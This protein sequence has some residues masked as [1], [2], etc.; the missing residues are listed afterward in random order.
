MMQYSG[1]TALD[2]QPYGD[3]AVII[4]FG[5]HISEE[6]NSRVQAAAACMEE[7]PF[8]GFVECIPAFTSLTVFYDVSAV[9]NIK[10]GVSP[11]AL[12]KKEVTER[13]SH[14]MTGRKK[15]RR[16]MEIPVCYGGD[17]GPDLEEVAEMN[18]L[19]P[20]DVTRIHTEGEYLV[21]MLGFAPGFPFLGGMSERIRAPRKASPRPSIPAGSVGIAGMQTGVYPIS[22]PGGWQLIGSTPLRLFRPE[23]HPPSLLRAGDTVKFV[24]ITAE[25][26]SRI[27]EGAE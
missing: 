27:K 12:V 14:I 20:E 25:E 13:L 24:R 22:T 1:N 15:E 3:S 2:I 7:R 21:Y 8:P 4:R 9:S 6:V 16:V 19:T 17:F 11:F 5:G 10:K 26:Y 23:E 18:D